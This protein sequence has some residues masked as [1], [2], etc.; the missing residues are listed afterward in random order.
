MKKK[1]NDMKDKFIEKRR[2]N[3]SGSNT[4][5]NSSADEKKNISR[6]ELKDLSAVLGNVQPETPGLPLSPNERLLR[7]GQ[8]I[9]D[10][11]KI[12]K[13][14]EPQTIPT[15]NHDHMRRSKTVYNEDKNNISNYSVIRKTL[16]TPRTGFKDELSRIES[17]PSHLNRENPDFINDMLNIFNSKRTSPIQD[18][19][20]NDSP[21]LGRKFSGSEKCNDVK[22]D[23]RSDSKF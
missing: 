7:L 13:E 20:S 22:I 4:S 15:E 9:E 14:E 17:G 21:Y 5:N 3:K 23:L 10:G 6:I 8:D 12:E 16:N 19:N 11:A 2:S 1:L 18:F